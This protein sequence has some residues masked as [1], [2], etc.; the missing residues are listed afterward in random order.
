MARITEFLVSNV[1]LILVIFLPLFAL[2]A[3]FYAPY[4]TAT[5]SNCSNDGLFSI[6]ATLTGGSSLSQY[7]VEASSVLTLGFVGLL[8]LVGATILAAVSTWIVANPSRE[9]RGITTTAVTTRVAA[10]FGLVSPL[11]PAWGCWLVVGC[12]WLS[13]VA[14]LLLRSD[15]L[16][17]R[18]AKW[19]S[20]RGAAAEEARREREEAFARE[21]EQER[22]RRQAEEA[23]A[24]RS[25]DGRPDGRT[26][27]PQRAR[28]DRP[29]KPSGPPRAVSDAAVLLGV[30]VSDSQ[31]TIEAAFRSWARTL[32]PDR[33]PNPKDATRQFQRVSN[34]RD[35]LIE[36][37]RHRG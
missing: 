23:R 14:A 30:N 1:W 27:P 18:E 9:E 16:A 37:A 15:L 21:Q 13:L 33:N 4:G 10:S 5:L 24:R 35:V 32:H 6:C 26:L 29:S 25:R 12:L 19:V 2:A 11:G 7:T 8:V 17:A 22:A 34:A 36:Y 28:Y 31:E 20:A 3:V